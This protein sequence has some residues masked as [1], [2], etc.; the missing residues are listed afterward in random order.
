[1]NP[2]P[3]T[4]W[5]LTCAAPGCPRLAVP[6]TLRTTQREKGHRALH[7]SHAVD[8]FTTAENEGWVREMLGYA[9]WAHYCL[10]HTDLPEHPEPIRQKRTTVTDYVRKVVNAIPDV[11]DFWVW[12]VTP[13]L[14]EHAIESADAATA[15]AAW[16]EKAA[17][18]RQGVITMPDGRMLSWHETTGWALWNEHGISTPLGVA[19]DAT[20]EQVVA[21]I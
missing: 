18:G 4:V 15:L 5:V 9:Q 21:R 17:P 1:M 14:P 12:E 20:P 19:V 10:D 11:Q 2:R 16:L 7:L 3:A 13:D 8:A 6:A